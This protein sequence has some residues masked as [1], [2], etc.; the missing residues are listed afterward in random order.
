MSDLRDEALRLY[1]ELGVPQDETLS[2]N[3]LTVVDGDEQE[4]ARRLREVLAH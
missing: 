2:F 4:I 3:M 1:A